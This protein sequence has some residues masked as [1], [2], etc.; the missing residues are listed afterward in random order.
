MLT[1][2]IGTSGR[3]YRLP[4]SLGLIRKSL[5]KFKLIIQR[6]DTCSVLRLPEWH[7]TC[8]ASPGS[9]SGI[10]QE[11]RQNT[12]YLQPLFL[13]QHVAKAARLSWMAK[14]ILPRLLNLLWSSKPKQQLQKAVLPFFCPPHPVLLLILLHLCLPHF[15]PVS[16]SRAFRP[17]YC[18]ISISDKT[19]KCKP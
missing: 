2:C 1:F 17:Q 3:K 4:F 5:Y 6:S 12:C 11:G 7:H 19:A 9:A 15:L 10:F 18:S 16:H 8:P 14:L 13:P